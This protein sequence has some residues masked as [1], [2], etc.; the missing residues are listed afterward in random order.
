M[1]V[2]TALISTP[3]RYRSTCN[4]A[5]LSAENAELFAHP[6][7]KREVNIENLLMN[8]E[9]IKGLLYMMMRGKTVELVSDS[10]R[11][12]YNVNKLA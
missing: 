8:I 1:E 9:D 6:A 4:E 10:D 2:T 3:A 5:A 7:R 12:G 11:V